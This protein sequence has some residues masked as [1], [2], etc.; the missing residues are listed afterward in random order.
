MFGSF[1][2]RRWVFVDVETTG[3][4]PARERV[5]EVGIVT[6]ETDGE[7]QRVGEWSSLVNPVVPIPPDVVSHVSTALAR[8]SDSLMLYAS[9]PCVSVCASIRTFRICGLSRRICATPSSV[10]NDRGMISSLS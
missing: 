8:A 3:A 6:V 5:T 10:G 1:A 2:D 7:A 9:L 4:S